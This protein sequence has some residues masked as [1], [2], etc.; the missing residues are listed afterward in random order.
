MWFS[1]KGAIKEYRVLWRQKITYLA[2]WRDPSLQ[3]KGPIAGEERELRRMTKTPRWNTGFAGGPIHFLALQ[4]QALSDHDPRFHSPSLLHFHYH[5]LCLQDV[6]MEFC[7][8]SLL[9]VLLTFHS[10]QDWRPPVQ[11]SWSFHDKQPSA[12]FSEAC[13]LTGFW[14]FGGCR[15]D[16]LA[17]QHTSRIDTLECSWYLVCFPCS[18]REEQVL[19]L[20]CEIGGS[21]H[22]EDSVTCTDSKRELPKKEEN[23]YGPRLELGSSKTQP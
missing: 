10:L 22:R 4:I 20:F 7:E 1:Y 21:A 17:L 18:G 14:V 3:N 15:P 2:L 23:I 5:V 8:D 12:G 13:L 9:G 11:G 6:H 16:S 19:W